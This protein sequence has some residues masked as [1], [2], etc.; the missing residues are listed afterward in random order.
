MTHD[1]KIGELSERCGVSPDTVRF[2]ERLG[3]LRQP[4]RTAAGH[5]TYDPESVERLRLIRGFQRLGLTLGDIRHLLR[6]R[7]AKGPDTGRKTLGVLRSRA[8]A[9]G[10]EVSRLCAFLSRLDESIRVWERRPADGFSAL[11]R[12]ASE[13]GRRQ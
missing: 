9:I 1:I 5:R 10:T 13:M 2:Y 6:L 7:Q 12:L 8:E 3:L 11:E 4:S